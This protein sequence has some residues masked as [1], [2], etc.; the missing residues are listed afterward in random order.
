VVLA[1]VGENHGI[2]V[3]SSASE[4]IVEKTVER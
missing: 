3:H 2:V 4:H 1:A